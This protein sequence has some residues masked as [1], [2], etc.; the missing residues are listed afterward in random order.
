MSEDPK[1]FDAGDYNLFR[2][3]HNDPIDFTDPMGLAGEASGLLQEGTNDRVWDMTH[4][5]DRSNLVQG[6]FAWGGIPY[7]MPDRDA[8][9]AGLDFAQTTRQSGREAYSTRFS[10]FMPF[11]L[12]WE[13]TT[14]END[15]HDPGGATKF[16]IDARSHPGVDIKNLTK[17]QATAIYWR[18]WGK[19]RAESL[20]YPLGEVHFNAYVN[21]GPDQSQ[22]F[23]GRS[24]ENA[25]S[26]INAQET[27]YRNLANSKRDSAR[28]LQGW[29]NRTEDL[30]KW[31]G[32]GP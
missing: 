15:P 29:I 14:Y 21:T 19:C 3:C 8:K 20:G 32:L 6:N 11:I 9:G 30:K 4:W 2:Y 7:A 28:Y 22:R 12:K 13:G 23:L 26:Y 24:G 5:F 27:F 18:D 31:L 1:L 17:E 10:G 25:L 16:G